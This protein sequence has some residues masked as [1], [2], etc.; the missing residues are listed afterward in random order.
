MSRFSEAFPDGDLPKNLNTFFGIR[1]PRA[2]PAD[3]ND[4]SIPGHLCWGSV[5]KLP[6]GVLDTADSFEVLD[7]DERHAE[8]SR[9]SDDIRI[10]NPDDSEQWIE[11]NRAKKTVY[12]KTEKTVGP[13]SNSSASEPE[14]IGDFSPSPI[15]REGFKPLGTGSTKKCRLTVHHANGPSS[16]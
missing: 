10:E 13:P 14:G 7:C 15:V 4:D 8:V 2:A 9:T 12:N 6:T 16:A 5:G 1:L 3:T 11:V